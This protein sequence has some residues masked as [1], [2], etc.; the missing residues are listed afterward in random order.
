MQRA[1]AL[2]AAAVVLGGIALV[3]SRLPSAPAS[4]GREAACAHPR[5][6]RAAAAGEVALWGHAKS[7]VRR[8]ARF[9]LRF[10]PALWLGGA[11]ANRAAREDGVIGPGDT[12]PNDYYVRDERHRLLTYLVPTNARVTVIT[13]LSTQC[14]T[15]IPVSELAAIVGGRNPRGRPLYD[16]RNA[17]G[18][19]ARISTD[20]V[21]S[22][23]Q[24]YQP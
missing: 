22:L 21:R 17:L 1:L 11:T 20:T 4:P 5:L 15:T 3:S 2:G 14:S 9:E 23:D 6:P 8:G 24:Q 13:G 19:W 7:L 12:V 16:R 18:F 10:D